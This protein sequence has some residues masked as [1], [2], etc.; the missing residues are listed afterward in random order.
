VNIS[1]IQERNQEWAKEI[2]GHMKYLINKGVPSPPLLLIPAEAFLICNLKNPIN[3][4]IQQIFKEYDQ[5][6]KRID[7]DE[8]TIQKALGGVEDLIGLMSSKSS[9]T[10]GGS[11][12][13][14]L[15]RKGLDPRESLRTICKE[16]YMTTKEQAGKLR[17]L[18]SDIHVNHKARYQRY[19]KTDNPDVLYWAYE[20]TVELVKEHW[21]RARRETERLF[22]Q[23]KVPITDAASRQRNQRR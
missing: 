11:L 15:K 13:K 7:Q 8:K 16:I 5:K 2:C 1:F 9:R 10:L 19:R 12:I 4:I 22:E 3:Q 20:G 17:P 21:G 6:L 23:W 18:F 14:A